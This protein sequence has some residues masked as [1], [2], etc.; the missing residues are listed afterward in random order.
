MLRQI[1]I[2]FKNECIFNH[3]YAMGFGD[4]ELT[5]VKKIIQSHLDLPMPGKT[6]ERAVT[7]YQIFHRTEKNVLFLFVTDLVDQLHRV[8]PIILKTIDK[9]NEFFKVPNDIVDS[10]SHRQDFIEFI[11]PLQHKLHSKIAIVGPTNAG[12]T[13]LFYLLKK[14]ETKE[15]MNF[16]VLSNYRIENLKFEIWDFILKDNF[17]LLWSKFISG[18]D[19]IILLFD[20]SNYHLSVIEHFKTLQKQEGKL[21]KFLIIGNKRD[22]VEDSDMKIIKNELDLNEFYDVSLVDSDIKQHFDSI[23][24]NTLNLRRSLPNN[25][26]EM[27]KQAERLELEGKHV[28]SIVKY[29][30]LIKICNDYQDL[31]HI[32]TFKDKVTE[33]Q[34]KIEEQNKLR[35]I[36]ESKEKFKV[37][38]KISFSQ[39]PMVKSLPTSQSNEVIDQ[40]KPEFS[41]NQKEENDIDQESS[42]IEDLTLFS[43]EDTKKK[44]HFLTPE[45]IKIKIKPKSQEFKPDKPKENT[46]FIIGKSIEEKSIGNVDNTAELQKL[47]ELKGSSLSINLCKQL[48]NDLQTALSRTITKEDLEMVADVFVKNEL[49]I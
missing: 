26:P 37:P 23:I 47:I 24:S 22:L 31:S 5:N 4:E 10:I 36:R 43:K 1:H 44:S 41:M 8:E 42:K 35:K 34:S 15:I 17:S 12:K 20:L 28:L 13:E 38:G 48:I 30:E 18:S 45:D 32:Q 27:I 11:N 19:L 6:F 29:K 40:V 3:S 33:I 7:N 49:K 9:F 25:F 39:K 46:N 14:G 16:A 21:S 2:F